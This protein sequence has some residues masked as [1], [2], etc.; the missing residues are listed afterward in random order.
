MNLLTGNVV[1]VRQEP[2]TFSRLEIRA[3]LSKALP[4]SWIRATSHTSLSHFEALHVLMSQARAERVQ[5]VL[6]IGK[7]WII[8]CIQKTLA[9]TLGT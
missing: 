2:H 9:T 4:V 5:Y 8:P 6:S 3:Q 1:A 7:N